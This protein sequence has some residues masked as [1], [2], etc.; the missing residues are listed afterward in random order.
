MH[1]THIFQQKPRKDVSHIGSN[2]NRIPFHHRYFRPWIFRI[3]CQKF[4]KHCLLLANS[5]NRIS[6]KN[7]IWC[8]TFTKNVFLCQKC[9]YRCNFLRRFRICF[10]KKHNSSQSW[11]ALKNMIFTFVLMGSFFSPSER[12]TWTNSFKKWVHH[13]KKYWKIRFEVIWSS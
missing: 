10:Q 6:T 3:W 1:W 9:C 2:K 4:A 11:V 7:R 8:A 13:F 5:K 12:P